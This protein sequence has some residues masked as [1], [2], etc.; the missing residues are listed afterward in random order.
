M[1]VKTDGSEP[2]TITLATVDVCKVSVLTLFLTLLV[3]AR[4]AAGESINS[5][6]ESHKCPYIKNEKQ[7]LH[8]GEVN[9][10]QICSFVMC[11]RL[12]K[13]ENVL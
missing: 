3:Q 5:W 12:T 13:S 9:N 2:Q 11:F 6:N 4:V 1:C 7:I 10:H 8:P